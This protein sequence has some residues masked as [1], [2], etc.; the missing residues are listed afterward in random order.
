[1]KLRLA[2]KTTFRWIRRFTEELNHKNDS[3]NQ[4]RDEWSC[5]KALLRRSRFLVQTSDSKL[6][7]SVNLIDIRYCFCSCKVSIVNNLLLEAIFQKQ[8]SHTKVKKK[9]VKDLTKYLKALF[10]QYCWNLVQNNEAKLIFRVLR[11]PAYRHKTFIVF[12]QN[13][14]QNF[15]REF[16]YDLVIRNTCRS[17]N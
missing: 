1:M 10:A 8:S 17:S 6:S 4:Q 2:A 3:N 16:L 13:K 15:E 9:T 5:F 12:S 7:F 11:V 14:K